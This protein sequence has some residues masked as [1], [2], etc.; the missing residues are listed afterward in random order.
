MLLQAG[1]L[2][3]LESSIMLQSHVRLLLLVL[4]KHVRELEEEVKN[5]VLKLSPFCT[6]PTAFSGTW[7]SVLASSFAAGAVWTRD[8]D[9]YRS[10]RNSKHDRAASL[11]HAQAT[12]MKKLN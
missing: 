3:V 6:L 10:G 12:D 5:T 1:S 11:L 2:P 8:Q 7:E 9:T 4:E